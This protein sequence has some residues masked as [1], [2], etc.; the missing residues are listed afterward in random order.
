MELTIEKALQQG[1]EAH[2][3]GK[4]QDAERLYRSILQSQPFHP[5]ANHN[6]GLLALH[7]NKTDAALPL[8]KTAVDVN[9]QIEQFWLSY[10]DALIKVKQHDK[11]K[12]VLEK[13]KKHGVA[14]EKLTFFETQFKSTTQVDKIKSTLKKTKLKLKDKRK[15]V[16]E[17][18]RNQKEKKQFNNSTNPPNTELNNLLLLYQNRKLAE[19]EELAISLTKRFPKHPFSWKV[20]G[21]LLKQTGRI[22]ESVSPMQRSLYLAPQDAEGHSNLGIT[23]KELGRLEEAEASCRQAIAFKANFAEAHFNLGITLKE[24]GRLEEAERSYA[25]AIA[26]KPHYAEAYSNL[27]NTLKDLG[28]LEEAEASYTQAINLKPDFAVAHYNLGNILKQL[29]R[30]EE[31]EAS[32][33]KAI[34]FKADFA[35]AYFNLGNTLKDLGRLEEAEASYTQA[36]AF[37]PDYPEA[38]SNLGVTLKSLGRLEEAEA[39]YT[40]AIAFKPDYPEAHSNLGNTLKELGQLDKAEASC[41]QAIALKPDFSEAHYNLSITL[42]ELGQLNEAEAS[43]RQAITFKP[44]YAEAHSN[45]GNILKQLGRLEEAKASYS[46]AIQ[47]KPD[48]AETHYNLSIILRELGRFKESAASCSQAIEFKP[49]YAEAHRELTTMKTYDALDEQYF[50]MQKLYLDGD[51]SEEQLCHINFGLAK[52]CEDLGN[53]EQAYKHYQEGNGLRKKI[54]NYHMNK[55]IELFKRIKANY[56]QIEK[57][58]LETDNLEKTQMPVFIVGMPRSGTT[59][60][61]QIISSHPQVMGA[62]ELP[63]VTQFGEAIANNGLSK[64]NKASLLDFR[65]TYQKKLQNI[66]NGCLFVTDKM[67]QN[68]HHIGLIAG[69]FP[70]AKII[71]VKRNPAAVCWANYKQYFVSENLGFCYA[72]DDIINYYQ[73]YENLMAFWEDSLGHRIYNLDYELLVKNQESETRQLI[74]N[75][76]LDWNEKFLSPQDN[77]RNVATASNLQVR[78]KVYQGSSQQWRKYEPFLGGAFDI[79]LPPESLD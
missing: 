44:N 68:F 36:I 46:Q 13:A 37:K 40:Q 18:K 14:Q 6:L 71:H 10:I 72:L 75:I 50:K 52:V 29:G 9:P 15:K 16:T 12:L 43:C 69:A 28:R 63:F 62:G 53:F 67:P 4:L 79:L 77:T 39:S 33:R 3:K 49:T 17:I 30:L 19:A 20:L 35:E 32:C 24:L 74:A 23:L 22:L 76:G 42:K 70:E 5:D 73:L 11:L 31:S 25:Q 54:L 7:A 78:K 27:G 47:L 64:I 57:N 2:R 34:A 26:L 61:E 56:L 66:S 58:S 45:L 59:L 51:T 60:V 21:I 1:V 41:K 65:K 48:F 38:H 8:L 55:D